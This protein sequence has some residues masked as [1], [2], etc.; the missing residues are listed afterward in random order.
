MSQL[1]RLT[2]KEIN[3]LTSDVKNQKL[4]IIRILKSKIKVYKLNK[5]EIKKI[6]LFIESLVN[7]NKVPRYLHE[8][9][10]DYILGVL[11]RP[12][13]AVKSVM[14]FNRDQILKRL[15]FDLATY[16][17]VPDQRAIE[18][19]R[20]KIYKS[21]IK[22]LAE[23][24]ESVGNNSAAAIG[25][26]LTQMSLDSFHSSGSANSNEA[27][28]KRIE[29]LTSPNTPRV[30]STCT[31]HFK[32]KNL[33]KEE[34]FTS[35]SQKMKGVSVED[36]I[37][38]AEPIDEI[39][40]EEEIWYQNYQSVYGEKIPL[41]KIFLRLKVNTYRCY[42]YDVQ[43]KDICD[44]IEKTTRVEINKKS[45]YCVCSSISEGI[46]DVHADEEF[47]RKTVTEFSTSGKTFKGCEKRYFRGKK[48]DEE[49]DD[50]TTPMQKTYLKTNLN[51]SDSL[52]D[53][54]LIFLTVI[55]KGCFPDM[56][57]LG[58]K[59]I[60]NIR[61]ETVKMNSEI[62]KFSR[63]FNDKDLNRFS[64]SPYNIKFEDLHRL[65]YVFIDYYSVHITG[66]PVDKF[67]NFFQLCGLKIIET[68]F[69]DYSNPKCVVM[70]P[71][72]SDQT[73]EKDGEMIKRFVKKDGII[74]DLKND[75]EVVTTEEPT[76][77][78]SRKL[79]EAEDT[80]KQTVNSNIFSSDLEIDY[81]EIYRAGYYSFAK[82]YGKSM[83]NDIL[84]D[85]FVDPYFTSSDSILDV[86]Q[87][88]GIESA[89]L[90][91]IKEYSSN[92]K[93]RKMNPVNIELLVDF[94]TSMGQLSGIGAS[95]IAKQGK[96]AL[97]AA[98][99]EEPI[100]AFMKA[101]TVGSKD[102]INNIASCL[103]SGK[104]CNNGTGICEVSFSQ[105]Y[106]DDES[107][108]F[109]GEERI[110]IKK[111]EITNREILGSCFGQG[112]LSKNYTG[113]TDDEEEVNI[114]EAQ[115]RQEDIVPKKK[116]GKKVSDILRS[117]RRDE[118]EED[119][120]HEEEM[121]ELDL[122]ENDKDILGMDESLFDF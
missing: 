85:K 64:A 58:I 89:R 122:P 36:L 61:T 53:L 90:F 18:S 35:Y 16:K 72:I 96:S 88:Y 37:E 47:I 120:F 82:A 4:D 19:L 117:K 40:P 93:I 110:E 70:M 103:M 29:N 12:P 59:G 87:Y 5:T 38:S 46:V 78:L 99:F 79:E 30:Y 1:R 112:V 43:L 106:L 60:E 109:K 34:I 108:K 97:Q 15:K 63:I 65:Y 2:D 31:I 95:D 121:P 100:K 17:M 42:I 91:L 41:S 21:F 115:T 52:K 27:G 22:S 107:S 11:P 114:L 81:P 33:T 83:F 73:F 94:Q 105:E 101:G 55:L 62:T 84:M 8:E 69:S 56:T 7:G 28:L 104:R 66:I 57:V 74:Y 6:K 26:L 98:S 86:Y 119:E 44:I 13:S 49:L 9:E 113:D 92:E 45:V 118:M 71:E 111:P 102:K 77:L 25:R 54:T 20:D 32:D 23:A 39:S 14:E 116:A 80:L 10:I 75:K 51:V 76:A 50:E 24:G 48:T 67:L 3:F 68:D